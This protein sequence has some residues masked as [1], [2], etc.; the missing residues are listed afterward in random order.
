[1]GGGTRRLGTPHCGR[2]PRADNSWLE[3]AS[4][5]AGEE[6]LVVGGGQLADRSGAVPGE[7]GAVHERQG[8]GLERKRASRAAA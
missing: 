5:A 4:L 6:A 7:R 8:A 2:G 3:L 1:M